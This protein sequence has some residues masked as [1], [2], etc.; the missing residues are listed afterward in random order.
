MSVKVIAVH[1]YDEEDDDFYMTIS[2][3]NSYGGTTKES[4]FISG[5]H[6]LE[7]GTYSD[8]I[9]RKYN[10]GDINDLLQQYYKSEGWK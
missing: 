1:H 8:R 7:A 5:N 10:V 3:E 9:D 6:I 4:Y 2:A